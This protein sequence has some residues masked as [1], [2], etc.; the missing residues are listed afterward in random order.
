[1]KIFDKILRCYVYP[2][3]NCAV[4]NACIYVCNNLHVI[5]LKNFVIFITITIDKILHIFAKFNVI[6]Y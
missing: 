4:I 6:F 5:I 1:M 3:P 2:I